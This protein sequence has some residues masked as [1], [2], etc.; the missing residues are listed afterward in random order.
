MTTELQ[1]K[2]LAR[3]VD[4]LMQ[5]VSDGEL[6]Y[7]KQDKAGG[8]ESGGR[9]APSFRGV[10]KEIKPHL[11]R[12][13]NGKAEKLANVRDGEPI[14]EGFTRRCD[15]QIDVSGQ[16]MSLSL[17]QTSLRPLRA[18]LTLLQSSGTLPDQVLT[19]FTTTLRSGQHGS[20]PVVCFKPIGTV[21]QE[22]QPV[23]LSVLPKSLPAADTP[24]FWGA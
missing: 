13:V 10:I 19:E 3:Q 4:E 18:Y 23:P 5:S 16:R 12:F 17:S 20:Y 21:S 2:N 22:Q 11:L 1:N 6:S 9:K 24:N 15:L 14:P 8:F 7:I